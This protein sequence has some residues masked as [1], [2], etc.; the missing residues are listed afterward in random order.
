MMNHRIK[1]GVKT[2]QSRLDCGVLC[3][4]KLRFQLALESI[5]VIV[6]PA[7]LMTYTPAN[8][9]S[10]PSNLPGGEIWTQK[11]KSCLLRVG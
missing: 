4:V 10:K 5:C 3:H 2:L 9:W 1:L 8:I 6:C 7:C 11:I